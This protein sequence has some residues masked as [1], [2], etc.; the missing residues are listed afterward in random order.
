MNNTFLSLLLITSLASVCGLTFASDEKLIIAHRGASGYLPEHT[1]ASKAMAH[2]MGAD[3]I[4][5]DV[6]MTKDDHLIVLHDP[7]LDRVSDVMD[8]YP[9]RNRDINGTNRWLAIDFTLAEVKTLKA[10]QSFRLNKNAA[11][12]EKI[13]DYPN[14]FP[15]FASDFRISTL[16]EEIELI[17]GLNHSTGKNVGIYTEIKAPWLHLIEGKD[18]S[19]AVLKLLKKYGYTNKKDKAFVQCFDAEE[20]QRI[21]DD[22]MPELGIDLKLVQL[23]APSDWGETQRIKNGKLERYNNDWLFKPGAMKLLAR[24]VDGIGPWNS[25]LIADAPTNGNIQFTNMVKDAHAAGLKVHP[26]T[27]RSDPGKVPDYA[28]NFEHL[29]EIFLFDLGVDGVFTD[30]PDKGVNYLRSR[31]RAAET[32]TA[33][34]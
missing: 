33:F 24:Y 7:F 14:R 18:I 20:V 9:S 1:L 21:H 17:Q 30:F 5:Q 26:Y 3:Y 31:V 4:E 10:S 27:F 22:L 8:R 28:R 23:I 2:A 6:V 32:S 11:K 16:E 25:L 12:T 19:L 13:A 34:Q 15:I 29:L